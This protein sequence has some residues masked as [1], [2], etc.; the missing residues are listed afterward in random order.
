[1]TPPR[2]ETFYRALN[3]G[4]SRSAFW[5]SMAWRSAGLNTPQSFNPLTCSAAFRKGKSV[6]NTI[7]EIGTTL[8]SADIAAGFEVCAVS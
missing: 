2:P 6:P 7:R 4:N 8:L 5:R 3:L 1:M